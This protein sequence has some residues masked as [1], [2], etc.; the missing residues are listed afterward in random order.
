MLRMS[1]KPLAFPEFVFQKK[2]NFEGS[3]NNQ[4]GTALFSLDWDRFKE[5]TQYYSRERNRPRIIPQEYESLIY[6]YFAIPSA[7]LDEIRHLSYLSITEANKY[8][9]FD[10]S[11]RDI[12]FNVSVSC[13]NTAMRLV[14]DCLF[15][16]ENG[17]YDRSYKKTLAQYA[18]MFSFW[19]PQVEV[20]K[21]EEYSEIYRLRSLLSLPHGILPDED[22]K[23]TRSFVSSLRSLQN[24]WYREGSD[25]IP[26]G[27]FE[28]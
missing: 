6:G 21:V 17:Y 3:S 16:V 28:D 25:T 24:E 18:L 2:V 27:I 19:A 26:S 1:H 4:K 13:V 5:Q 22:L 14:A 11:I 10:P 15:D 20:G 12:C 23:E 7:Y 8:K 9:P